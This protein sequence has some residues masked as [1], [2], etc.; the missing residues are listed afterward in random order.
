MG[1]YTIRLDPGSQDICSIITPFGKYNYLRLLI[2][3]M[4]APD[5]VQETMSNLING[6]EFAHTY[7][8]YLVCL[9]KDHFNGHLEERKVFNTFVKRK[10][11]DKYK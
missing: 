8:D 4:C 5:I 2:Y 10:P 9:S 3:I 11:S 7:I 6:L 1:Y